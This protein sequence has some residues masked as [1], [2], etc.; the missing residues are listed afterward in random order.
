MCTYSD[1]NEFGFFFQNRNSQYNSKILPIWHKILYNQSINRN[2]H[3]AFTVPV[4][5][6]SELRA[7]D[8]SSTVTSN[9]G[10][11]GKFKIHLYLNGHVKPVYNI[12]TLYF[13]V[14]ACFHVSKLCC[15]GKTLF[16]FENP[17]NPTCVLVHH[18]Q[19]SSWAFHIN[20]LYYVWFLQ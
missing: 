3:L 20:L 10:K 11:T 15:C 17:L 14:D 7:K 8:G 1:I 9:F 6:S 4:T 5:L 12:C 18:N 16:N 2:T 19:R 13:V